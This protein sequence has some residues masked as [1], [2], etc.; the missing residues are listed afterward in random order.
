MKLIPPVPLLPIKAAVGKNGALVLVALLGLA[1]YAT[2][3]TQSAPPK[4]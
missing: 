1:L 4:R 3:K 2:A